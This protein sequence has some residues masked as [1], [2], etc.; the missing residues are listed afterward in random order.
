MIYPEAATL[1]EH[2]SKEPFFKETHATLIGGTAIAYQSKHRMSF[3]LDIVLLLTSIKF[4]E[5]DPHL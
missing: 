1:L 2:F 3:D 5:I 4:K